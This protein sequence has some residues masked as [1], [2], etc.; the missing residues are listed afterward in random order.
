MDM[1]V[2]NKYNQNIEIEIGKNSQSRRSSAN[3]FQWLKPL[4][5]NLPRL[6]GF[7][8]PL[9]QTCCSLLSALR[10]RSKESKAP[11]LQSKESKAP[12][13]QSKESEAPQLQS[14]ESEEFD[15][16]KIYE[17]GAAAI[18][19]A[20]K[21]G[22]LGELQSPRKQ[23]KPQLKTIPEQTLRDLFAEEDEESGKESIY[24][25]GE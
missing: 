11:Q 9:R 25:E 14:K 24:K 23:F 15:I 22:P 3:C 10:P 18:Q 7:C 5:P 20:Q 1:K 4:H 12:Q 17:E 8:P 6:R 19:K 16:K 21:L 13:L 2:N